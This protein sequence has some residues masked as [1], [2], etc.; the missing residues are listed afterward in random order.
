MVPFD[1]KM[2]TWYFHDGAMDD[3]CCE[4][5]VNVSEIIIQSQ[6][7]TNPNVLFELQMYAPDPE[8]LLLI[9]R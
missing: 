5:V 9:A 1:G 8:I 6:S 7:I 4:L 3:P 2:R